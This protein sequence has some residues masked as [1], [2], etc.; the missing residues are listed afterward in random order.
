[1][2]NGAD[3]LWAGRLFPVWMAGRSSA[4]KLAASA[5]TLT[6][7]S[8]TYQVFPQDTQHPLR[9]PSLATLSNF[10][11]LV[12]LQPIVTP[13]NF[14]NG[15]FGLGLGAFGEGFADCESRFGEFLAA[16]GCAIALPTSDTNALPDYVV[17]QGDFVPQ[18][19]SLYALAGSGDFPMMVR[20]DTA[21]EGPGQIGLSELVDGLLEIVR[22]RVDR[23]CCAR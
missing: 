17:E 16:A 15:T 7:A 14:A 23:V 22:L 10:D 4:A 9:A 5:R 12:S 20:F 19:E 1:M 18:V 13:L 2:Q 3:T 6:R 21:S 11:Q 8:A